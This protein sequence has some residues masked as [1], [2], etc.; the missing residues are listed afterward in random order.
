MEGFSSPLGAETGLKL[1]KPVEGVS[2]LEQ[3]TFFEDATVDALPGDI[4]T[5]VDKTT[6]SNEPGFLKNLF[7][8]ISNQDSVSYTHLTLPTTPYV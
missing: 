2:N 4:I 7:D 6:V 8:G 1:G 3:S 5:T